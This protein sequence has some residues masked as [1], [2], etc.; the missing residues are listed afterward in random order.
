MA[1]HNIP[2]TLTFEEWR[3]DYNSLATDLG[4]IE[5]GIAGSNSAGNP[6]Y[7]TV[8]T[9]LDG[10][11]SDI[12]NITG[13]SYPLLFADILPSSSQTYD[14]GST[15]YEWRDLYISNDVSVGNNIIADGT[16]TINSQVNSS[17]TTTGSLIVDGGVGISQTVTIGQDLNVLGN[18]TLNT[19]NVAVKGYAISVAIA[20]GWNI[21]I[22]R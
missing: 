18:I 17:S 4:D 20:L 2:A 5:S 8:E 14:L 19:E 9:A 21:N 1:V 22:E 6:T 12:N 7:T 15:N 16:V 10:L 3:L 11:V 13:G